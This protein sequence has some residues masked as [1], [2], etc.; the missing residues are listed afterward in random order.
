MTFTLRQRICMHDEAIKARLLG[1][2]LSKEAPL[3]SQAP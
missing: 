2:Y 1:D 3:Q